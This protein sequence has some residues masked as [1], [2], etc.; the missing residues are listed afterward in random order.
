MNRDERE[1]EEEKQEQESVAGLAG[2][3]HRAIG[4]ASDIVAPRQE[5]DTLSMIYE[6]A[7]IQALLENTRLTPGDFLGR[8]RQLREKHRAGKLKKPESQLGR[9]NAARSEAGMRADPVRELARF[10]ARASVRAQRESRSCSVLLCNCADR[11]GV[12][13]A[14]AEAVADE[15]GSILG[16]FTSVVAGHLIAALVISDAEIDEEPVERRLRDQ[17]ALQLDDVQISVT[18]LPADDIDLRIPG[19]TCWHATA[20]HR[21]DEPLLL[22]LTG[23]IADE[24][25]PVVAMSSWLESDASTG[26]TVQVVDLNFVLSADVEGEDLQSLQNIEEQA[27]K[28]MSKM[29]L[30]IVPVTWPT[31]SWSQRHVNRPGSKV[32]VMTVVGRAQVGFVHHVVSTLVKAVSAVVEIQNSSMALLDGTSVLTIMFTRTQESRLPDIERQIRTKLAVS[33]TP[34]D[35]QSLAPIAVQLVKAA[36]GSLDEVDCA[37]GSS[38]MGKREGPTDELSIVAVEQPRVVA[39]VAGLLARFDVNIFWFVSHIL[40]PVVG[41]RWPMYAQQM[42]VNVPE[43]ERDSVSRSLYALGEAEGWQEVSMRPWSIADHGNRY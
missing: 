19:S 22:E 18:P 40:D 32:A 26:E 43:R 34:P 15:R 41:E 2:G 5:V 27:K 39:K 1:G 31:R 8:Y 3:G 13:A 21:G 37:P 12:L 28:R 36:K 35:E 33:E 14:L 16:A 11:S 30:T 25:V 24:G 6:Q 4:W 38:R 42:H 29:Q 9:D 17:S 23:A 20:R 10:G 7:A